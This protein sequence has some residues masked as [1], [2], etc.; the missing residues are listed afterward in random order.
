MSVLVNGA[1]SSINSSNGKHSM[2]IFYDSCGSLLRSEL[3]R[4]LSEF[5]KSMQGITRATIGQLEFIFSS[6]KAEAH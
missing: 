3:K 2:G 6:I 4:S 5:I 1:E